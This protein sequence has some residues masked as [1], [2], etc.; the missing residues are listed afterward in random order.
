MT[1]AENDARRYIKNRSSSVGLMLFAETKAECLNISKTLQVSPM[2]CG[3]SSVSIN[4]LRM[5]IS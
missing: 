3:C 1:D 2:A 4:N 5:T